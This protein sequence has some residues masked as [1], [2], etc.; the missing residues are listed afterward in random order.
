MGTRLWLRVPIWLGGETNVH[1]WLT[2]DTPAGDTICRRFRIPIEF[3]AAFSGAVAALTDAYNWEA[4]GDLTPD[5]AA[6]EAFEF[7]QDE[8]VCMSTTLLGAVVAWA[9]DALPNN[10]LL[11]DGSVIDRIDYPDLWDIWPDAY[12]DDDS[13][14]LPDIT[15]RFIVGVGTYDD[16]DEGGSDTVTLSAGEI[17]SHTHNINYAYGPGTI[18]GYV[19]EVPGLVIAPT[20]ETTSATGSGNAHE[21]RPPFIALRWC[22][23]VLP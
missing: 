11:A 15:D 23:V 2:P 20:S 8:D 18:A 3:N 7:T 16:R 9:A 19:G 1:G 5:E 22:V 10:L 4:Y 21:N 14:T 13:L 17:P 12:K 6:S